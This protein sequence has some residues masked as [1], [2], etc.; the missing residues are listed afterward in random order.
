MIGKAA[1]IYLLAT[2]WKFSKPHRWTM[3]LGLGQGGEFARPAVV[4][5]APHS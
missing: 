2:M 4:I 3:A 5:T 1:I